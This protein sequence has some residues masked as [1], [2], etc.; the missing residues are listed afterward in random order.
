MGK[1]Y[2]PTFV[3]FTGDFKTGQMR[4]GMEWRVRSRTNLPGYGKPTEENLKK[5]AE[6]FNAS[7]LPGGTN[8]HIGIDGQFNFASIINQKTGDELVTWRKST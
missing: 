8:E 1:S 3:V 5:W 2:T 6:D 4:P 7:F